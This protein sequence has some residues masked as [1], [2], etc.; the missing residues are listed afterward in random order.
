VNINESRSKYPPRGV[1]CR[2]TQLLYVTDSGNAT[3]VYGDTSVRAGSTGPIDYRCVADDEIV[4]L[5]LPRTFD[6]VHDLP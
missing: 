4:H 2:P 5:I 6:F 1:D 3:A